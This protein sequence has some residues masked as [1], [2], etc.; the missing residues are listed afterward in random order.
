MDIYSNADLH[1]LHKKGISNHL[2]DDDNYGYETEDEDEEFY[3][4]F[5][6]DNEEYDVY[7]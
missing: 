3:N 4:V 6:E 5:E 7:Y 1:D 2:I